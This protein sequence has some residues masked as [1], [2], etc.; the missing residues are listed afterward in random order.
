MSFLFLRLWLPL[1]QK[2]FCAH[3]YLFSVYDL[4]LCMLDKMPS[5]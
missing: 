2:L 4:A 3:V 1:E 5:E